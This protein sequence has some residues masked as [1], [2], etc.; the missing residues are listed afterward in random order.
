MRELKI[1]DHELE[2]NCIE[3]ETLIKYSDE[4]LLDN[5]CPSC[6]NHLRVDANLNEII[7]LNESMQEIR[8][9]PIKRTII[10]NTEDDN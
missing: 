10:I 7:L 3:C 4:S 1:I 5:Q 6:N 8:R 9:E 2:F